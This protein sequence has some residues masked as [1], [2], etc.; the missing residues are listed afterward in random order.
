MTKGINN[1]AY[2]QRA[3]ILLNIFDHKVLHSGAKQVN[4]VC[5]IAHII[6][7]LM[8]HAPSLV[9]E[10]QCSNSDCRRGLPVRRPVPL[11]PVDGGIIEREGIQGLQAALVEGVELQPSICL[12]P[13]NT[14]AAKPSMEVDPSMP[15]PLCI[16]MVDHGY[17][18]G[19]A[20]WVE[21]AAE[22]TYRL[23]DF[24]MD[25]TIG[26]EQFLLRGVVHFTPGHDWQAMGH[27]VAFCRRTFSAWERYDD[28]TKGVSTVQETHSVQPHVLFYTKEQ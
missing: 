15:A 16:G 7:R 13:L 11:V 8:N 22:C 3:E 5:N 23:Q 21:I 26:N 4:S 1:D 25:I 14:E 20:L 10:T 27:Y 2:R 28:L 17:S 19:A 18:T 6:T 24:P 9:T 12:R